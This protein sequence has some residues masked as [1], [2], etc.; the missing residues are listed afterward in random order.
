MFG[1]KQKDGVVLKLNTEERRLLRRAMV[2][3]RNEVI[4]KGWPTED[5]DRLILRLAK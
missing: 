2:E 5:I 3:F 1:R 4:A